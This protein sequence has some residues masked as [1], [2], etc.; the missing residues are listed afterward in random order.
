MRLSVKLNPSWRL[1]IP[2]ADRRLWILRSTALRIEQHANPL[3]Q[4][5]IFW[6]R[7][8]VLFAGA[9]LGLYLAATVALW[10]FLALN[11]DNQIGWRDILAMPLDRSSFRKKRGDTAILTG[12]RQFNERDFT[13]AYF[14]LRAGLARSPGNVE[15]RLLL[16][17]QIALADSA[18]VITL[19]EDGVAATG[20]DLRLLRALFSYYSIFQVRTRALLKSEELLAATGAHALSA[21]SRVFVASARAVLLLELGRASDAVQQLAAIPR[22]PTDP[23]DDNRLHLVEIKALLQSGRA[24]E[25]R[26]AMEQFAPVGPTTTDTLYLQAE[27]A[28]ALEDSVAL[29]SALIKMKGL[30]P[31]KPGPLLYAFRAWHLLKRPTLRDAVEQEIYAAFGANDSVLQTFAAFLVNLDLPE[32]IFRVQTVAQASHLSLFAFQVHL[33]EIALRRGDFERATRLLRNWEYSVVTL[34]GRQRFY[35]EF[36]KLL[37][38]AAFADNDQNA[39][40]L[41]SFMA[42]SRGQ[43]QLPV[44]QLA[45][46]VLERAGNLSAELEVLRVALTRFPFSDSLQA[47]SKTLDMKLAVASAEKSAAAAAST[48]AAAE[49]LPPTAAAALKQFDDLLR[50]DALTPARDLLRAVRKVR[51]DWLAPQ[52]AEFGLRELQL[53]F[54]SQDLLTTRN[55]VRQYLG[56]FHDEA[57]GLNLVRLAADLA[58]GKHLAAARMLHDELRGKFSGNIRVFVA[59]RE[60]KLPDDLLP[61]TA[62]A[63]STLRTLD[64]WLDTRQLAQAERVFNYLRDQPPR[65]FASSKAEVQVRE[66]RLRLALDQQPKAL[67]VFREVVLRPGASRSTAFRLVH[68]TLARGEQAHALVLATE[69]VRLLPD[70]PT[71][72]K[73]LRKVQAPTPAAP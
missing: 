37:T 38:R 12:I 25:A 50:A 48:A 45:V 51:P 44:W 58:A 56:Q 26:R 15:G 18:Y 24:P 33:T 17:R 68:E 31:N 61:T 20:E 27:I 39:T 6:K 40:A 69:I 3:W 70:N 53:A 66:V 49:V 72:A 1:E 57:T 36:L 73:L 62:V 55:Q 63:A 41:V 16:A 30:E 59:L 19:L 29:Q 13:E 34:S 10:A 46:T 64:Q 60:L 28:I 35:P 23:D 21:E 11:S 14:N 42:G 67:A 47:A 2:S 65:W 54:S 22:R 8:L 71:A 32:I 9:G 4:F 52:E 7:L 5:E 43:V